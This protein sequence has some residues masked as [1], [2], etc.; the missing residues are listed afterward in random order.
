[1]DS[2]ESFEHEEKFIEVPKLPGRPSPAFL[3]FFVNS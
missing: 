3:S 1:M 2:E